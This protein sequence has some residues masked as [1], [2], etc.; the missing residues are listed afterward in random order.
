MRRS[1]P[2]P[3]PHPATVPAHL[4]LPLNM[5]CA[6]ALSPPWIPHMGELRA[7]TDSL[8]LR[9]RFSFPLHSD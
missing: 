1:Y 5:A 9:S 4:R 7:R 6:P 2:V 8:I 3:L